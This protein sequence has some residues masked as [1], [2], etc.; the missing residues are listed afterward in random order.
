MTIHLVASLMTPGH[1]RAAWRLPHNDPGDHLSI[2]YFQGLARVADEVGLDAIFLGDAPALSPDI[3]SHPANGIDPLVLLGNLAAITERVGVL[4]TSSTTYNS[5]Y[6]LARRFQALDIVTRGRAAVNLVTTFAGGASANFGYPENPDKET[7]YRRAY[8]FVQVVQG[9]WDGWEPGA[10][11]ADKEAGRYADTDRIHPIEHRGEFFSVRGPLPTPAGPQGRPVVCQAGGS[12]G[13]L[14]LGAELADVIFTVA[15]T[16]DKA[17]AF[18]DDI[19]A[20]AVAAGRRADD[21]KVSLGVIV[22]VGTDE[23]DTRARFE[24]LYATVPED[25]IAR[26]TLALLGLGERDLDSPISLADLPE[27]PVGEAGSAGFQVS[28][29][30]ML[31]EGPLTPRELVRRTAGVA[32]GG[33]RLLAGT[34]EQIADDL[35]R[36]HA[37]GAADGFT[38]MYADTSV[39]FERFARLVV[40]LLVERGLFVPG[41]VGST[42]RE[43]LGLPLPARTRGEERLVG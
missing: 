39:D 33:H 24:E 22:L 28:T 35:A 40:P 43:R 15:Q 30:G 17:V 10:I 41:E 19:R 4:I 11:V 25:E 42:L 31:K 20:R 23:D 36:W 6:N 16:Q 5:P 26:T 34:P 29:R 1:F 21:V 32:G 8:E 7:R 14:R 12:E 18:R 27:V 9:L 2:D 38:I 3:A 13:G 37:A